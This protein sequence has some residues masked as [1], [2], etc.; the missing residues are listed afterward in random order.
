MPERKTFQI[1]YLEPLATNIG[2]GKKWRLG[3]KYVIR[4]GL[5]LK[6]DR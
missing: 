3:K 4:Q 2:V 5:D 1:G 6:R